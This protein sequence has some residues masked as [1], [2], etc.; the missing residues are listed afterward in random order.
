[1]Q[2]VCVDG[3]CVLWNGV[4]IIWPMS[5]PPTPSA[6]HHKHAYTKLTHDVMLRDY[7][8][9]FKKRKEN[10]SASDLGN[11][12]LQDLVD[13]VDGINGRSVHYIQDKPMLL[14]S[15]SQGGDKVPVVFL[16]DEPQDYTVCNRVYS[17]TTELHKKLCLLRGEIDNSKLPHSGTS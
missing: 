16:P 7:V 6:I 5:G 13:M 3:C 12:L 10:C 11:T 2:T 17:L 15:R 1:M 9:T 14:S 8:K 4:G